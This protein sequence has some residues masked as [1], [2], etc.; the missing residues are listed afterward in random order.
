MS[1]LRR[2][3]RLA[4]AGACSGLFSVSVSLLG[5]RVLAYYDYLAARGVD[6]YETSYSSGVEDLWWVPV[7]L[8]HVVLS[9]VASLL[10]HR[11]V[12]RGQTSTFLRWQIIG[13]VA[14]AG[15]SLTMFT[16]ITM[17]CMMRGNTLPVERA[18][19]FVNLISVA[20]FVAAVFA[21]N[22][23]YGTAIHAACID[24]TLKQNEV[25]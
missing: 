18:L 19:R 8:W 9:V 4:A 17:D 14:L 22:V 24:D 6:G 1:K 2:D 12:D 21:S 20:Q 23:L 5:Y 10:V 3:L 16:G 25:T 15:W 11:Y 7:V 13:F